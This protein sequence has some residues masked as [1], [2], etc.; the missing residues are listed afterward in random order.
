V[1]GERWDAVDEYV[2]QRLIGEDTALAAALDASREAGLPQIAVTPAQG[3]LLHL[4]ARVHGA[5]R[6]L[7]LGTLGGYSTIWLARALP[8]DGRLVTLELDERYARIAQQSIDR[9]GVG[10]RVELRVGP[11][12]DSLRELVA[13]GA[14]D[15]DLVF[16]DADKRSTPEYFSESMKLTRLG[17]VIVVDNV[18]RAGAL[19]DPGAEDPGV[20]GMPRFH[21]LLAR[22]PRVSAT[23]IQTVGA[24]GYDGF[25]FALVVSRDTPA[26]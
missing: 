5:R 9:A 22:E 8:A 26:V 16:I 14:E 11:A 15:F 23:T 20:Q 12:L 24:K 21:E 6:V 3:K 17:G 25:T 13:E 2:E 1:S 7:E 10:E 19:A 4:L 18:V